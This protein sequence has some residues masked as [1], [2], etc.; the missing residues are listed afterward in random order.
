MTGAI[1]PYPI[2]R[3]SFKLLSIR[4]FSTTP[5]HL[6]PEPESKRFLLHPTPTA[7][8]SSE[9]P[10]SL[11]PL[12]SAPT[13]QPTP[14]RPVNTLKSLLTSYSRRPPARKSAL[15][16]TTSTYRA[17]DLSSHLHR[18]FRPGDIY[19]PHDLSPVEQAKWRPRRTSPRHAPPL[20]SSKAKRSDAFDILNMHPLN[21]YAN[22]NMMSSEF[23]S[24]MG[25][26]KGRRE[27]GLRGVNQRRVSRAVRRA[28]GMGL[29]PS[30]HRHPEMLEREKGEMAR[31]RSN[32]AGFRGSGPRRY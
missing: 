6:L 24:S 9:P 12:P 11:S 17:T 30:V 10:P 1:L 13:S 22:F 2:L 8:R 31:R 23:V 19:S 29:V 16:E 32:S 7:N 15:A 28:V 14:P 21:E 25:R 18:R 5:Q 3:Q 4:S 27:T 26:L 20:P